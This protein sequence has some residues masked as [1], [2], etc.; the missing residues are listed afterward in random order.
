MDKLGRK[1]DSLLVQVKK[2]LS[3]TDSAKPF[4]PH[5]SLNPKDYSIRKHLQGGTAYFNCNTW[6]PYGNI[7]IDKRYLANTSLA[8]LVDTIKHEEAHR[9]DFIISTNKDDK[10]FTRYYQ[11]GA[12]WLSVYASLTTDLSFIHSYYLC[13]CGVQKNL[14]YRNLSLNPS[15]KAGLE[16]QFK[17]GE[18]FCKRPYEIGGIYLLNT[19]L[20]YPTEPEQ[21]KYVAFVKRV[22]DEAKASKRWLFLIG[23]NNDLTLLAS[24]EEWKFKLKYESTVGGSGWHLKF[25]KVNQ[26]QA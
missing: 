17:C 10:D 26:S 20:K 19:S 11:H 12:V 7:E 25:E 3:S 21:V 24:G 8:E 22:I 16:K 23:K 4:L 14:M 18:I 13:K 2:E 1:L 6:R 15:D 9:V 5:I